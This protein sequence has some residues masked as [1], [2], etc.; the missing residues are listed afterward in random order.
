MFL[1]TLS[2]ELTVPQHVANVYELVTYGLASYICGAYTGLKLFNGSAYV[3]CVMCLMVSM[4]ALIRMSCQNNLKRFLTYLTM[5]STLGYA[6][7]PLIIQAHQTDTS[8]LMLACCFTLALFFLFTIVARRLNDEL[9]QVVGLLCSAYLFLLACIPFILLLFPVYVTSSTAYL[10]LGLLTFAGFISYSTY[11]M[12][13][14]LGRGENDYYCHIV[15]LFRDAVNL[16]V[17]I[18]NML[19]KTK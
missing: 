1:S 15:N 5:T 19:I 9:A 17:K 11:E 10:F 16:F 8:I 12:H 4:I 3:F 2:R 18:T 7:S 6:N 13:Q 14:R